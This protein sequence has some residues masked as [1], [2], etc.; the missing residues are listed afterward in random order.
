ML[1][2]RAELELT[3]ES[4]KR[5]ER[6]LEKAATEK[7][8]SPQAIKTR[9]DL[10]RTQHIGIGT[11][12]WVDDNPDWNLHENLMLRD[13]GILITQTLNTEGALRYLEYPEF[14]AVLTDVTRN[15]D[16]DAGFGLITEMRNRGHT[17]PV[18]IYSMD[19]SHGQPARAEA[20]GASFVT[21]PDELLQAVLKLRPSTGPRS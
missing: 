11:A 14:D 10:A 4:R 19:K 7:G 18:I 8:E 1:G 13:L 9:E 21:T 12:L 15:G 5:A 2:L 16:H 17:Q 3:N 20:L 6:H